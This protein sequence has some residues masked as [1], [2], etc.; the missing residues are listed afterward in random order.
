[1]CL[2]VLNLIY[3]IYMDLYVSF[4][5][6]LVNSFNL[7]LSKHELQIIQKAKDLLLE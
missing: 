4:K 5:D 3:H 7:K 6:T 2:M 1:M